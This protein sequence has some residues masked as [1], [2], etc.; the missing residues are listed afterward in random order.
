MS[1]NPVMKTN[2]PYPFARH[3]SG[4]PYTFD[5][6]RVPKQAFGHYKL[7]AK[8]AADTKTP[9][10]STS[11]GPES[12]GRRPGPGFGPKS[13]NPTVKKILFLPEQFWD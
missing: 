11:P 6:D 4:I 5:F 7:S 10:K 2:T 3:C 1:A 12:N 13:G 9:A 8:D